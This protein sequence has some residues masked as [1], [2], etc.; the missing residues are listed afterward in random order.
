M[1]LPSVAD[2]ST[3]VAIKSIVLY[4]LSTIAAALVMSIGLVASTQ[5]T[6]YHLQNLYYPVQKDSCSCDCW[7]GFFRG[8]HS[9]GG[10]KT[11]YFNYDRQMIAILF[12][13]LFYAEMLRHVLLNMALH[14]RLRSL[15]FIPAIY[16][17]FYGVWSILNYL[18]DHDYERMLKSQIYFS[19]TELIASY[20]FYQ[21]LLAKSK[22]S[23]PP[24]FIYVLCT[25]SVVHIT[26][27]CGELNIDQMVRN[28]A[29]T[30]SDLINIAWAAHLFAKNPKLRP[31]AR[32]IGVCAL[33]AVGLWLFYH[34]VCPF[35]E[36]L[37]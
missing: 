28:I 7:D 13:V 31:T 25:I 30:L 19:C 1:M 26:L 36:R 35:R 34:L 12:L 9:R 16:S 17:N 22:P 15:V 4:V 29:L 33:A 3:G 21:C 8:R 11:F 18:N 20:I 27:A 5:S 2:R 10:Y 37:E 14:R 32:T 23:V 6:G 24:W